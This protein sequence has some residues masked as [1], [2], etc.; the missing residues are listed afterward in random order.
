MKV[1]E[2]LLAQSLRQP[3]NVDPGFDS[4]ACCSPKSSWSTTGPGD[5]APLFGG[6]LVNVSPRDPFTLVMHIAGAARHRRPRQ[7]GARP[8]R[9]AGRSDGVAE[10]GIEARRRRYEGGWSPGEAGQTPRGAPASVPSASHRPTIGA[11]RL[12][13]RPKSGCCANGSWALG[14]ESAITWCTCRPRLRSAPSY[15][16]PTNAGRSS[17]STRNSRTNL[18]LDHCEGR[19]LPDWRRHVV[20]TATAYSFL[21]HERGRRG[22]PSSPCRVCA[23]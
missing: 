1:R 20:L 2:P 6:L 13:S 19:S 16:W 17:S 4:S 3:R 14:I 10:S 15:N 18:G 8:P 21:Q 23:W 7:R 12:V 11:S 5:T 9:G 22:Q